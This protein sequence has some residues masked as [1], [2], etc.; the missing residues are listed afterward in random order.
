MHACLLAAVMSARCRHP[1]RARLTLPPL[2]A[3]RLR[4]ESGARERDLGASREAVAELRVRLT[5]AQLHAQL[6]LDD[7]R[8]Q[9]AR[10]QD[11]LRE[12]QVGLCLPCS[13]RPKG[14]ESKLAWCEYYLLGP[15]I[16]TSFD[17]VWIAPEWACT[18]QAKATALIEDVH[19][20]KADKTDLEASIAEAQER[21]EAAIGKLAAEQEAAATVEKA[22]AAAVQACTP[23]CV[24]CG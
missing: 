3:E 12:Q 8:E 1:S 17:T 5:E 13:C 24:A 14:S 16:W 9:L 7:L 6:A 19:A 23:V 20:L 10:S 22:R 15:W 4:R 21:A 18:V 2:Q 11:Y